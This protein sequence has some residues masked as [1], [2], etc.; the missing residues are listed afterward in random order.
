MSIIETIIQDLRQ[1]PLEH[2]TKV[3]QLVQELKAEANRQLLA[4]T[5]QILEATEPLPV[6]TWTE[7][8]DY[9]QQL[10]INL[11]DRPNPFRDEAAAT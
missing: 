11:M 7:I 3:H 6:D 10:R 8:A 2:L 9:Q 5:L 4:N 1:V